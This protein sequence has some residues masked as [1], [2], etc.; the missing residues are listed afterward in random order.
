MQEYTLTQKLMG[1]VFTLGVIA[2]DPSEAR[3]FL[4]AGIAEIERLE[5]LLS[6]FRPDSATT[7]IN[8]N[9]GETWVPTDAETYG[10]I[11]RSIAIARL[12]GGDFDITVAPLKS[13]YRFKHTD[14]V[15]PADEEISHALQKVGYHHLLLDDAAQAVRFAVSGMRISFAAIG[16]GFAA[17]QVIHKWKAAG[18]RSGFVSASGDIRVL[19]VNSKGLPWK[20]GIAHPDAIGTALFQLSLRDNAIATSGSSEQYFMWNKK[21]WSHNINPH[22]GK[23]LQGIKSVTIVS[24]AAE[25]AD[26]LATAVY[27]KGIRKGLAFVDQLPQTHA[28]I[29]D[30]KNNIHFSKKLVYETVTADAVVPLLNG[31]REPET[32]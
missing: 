28:V 4:E 26:A 16:K 30:E 8:N 20:A 23:P 10:L 25:L 6:E 12:C 5:K 18:L 13:L 17:D 3:V 14:F 24:P 19:G 27:V 22:T 2:G 1:T 21:K 15:M 32:V 31:V 29:I 7:N 11:K 9:A